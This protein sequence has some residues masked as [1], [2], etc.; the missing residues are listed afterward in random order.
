MSPRCE[1]ETKTG[2]PC[3]YRGRHHYE[4]QHVCG[5]H[6]RTIKLHEDCAICLESLD[7]KA[8]VTL[9]C[10][11][12]YHI[13]CLVQ[14]TCVTCPT[15]RN[16]F[17]LLDLVRIYQDDNYLSET[18]SIILKQPKEARDWALEVVDM[19]ASIAEQG[20][21][22]AH[23]SHHCMRIMR[24]FANHMAASQDI[25]YQSVMSVFAKAVVYAVCHGGSLDGFMV[26]GQSGNIYS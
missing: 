7:A 16:G 26:Y 17:R 11:H 19:V 3:P 8:K 20:A 4:G 13:P 12:T 9:E 5:C 24:E 21:Y 2:R 14:G 22:E 10:G 6:L 25:T 23:A 1:A 15:C 18:L